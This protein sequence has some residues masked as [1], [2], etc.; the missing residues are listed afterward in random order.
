MS[1]SNLLCEGEERSPDVILLRVLLAG[2][3]AVEPSGSKFGMDTRVLAWRAA[4]PGSTAA[5]LRDADLAGQWPR[6]KDRPQ[7]WI[8]SVAGGQSVNLGWSWSRTEIENYLIDPAVVVAALGHRAPDSGQYREILDRAAD[9]LSSYTAARVALSTSRIAV[10]QLNNQWGT[11]RGHDKHAFPKS[12]EKSS[13]RK[14]L[15]RKVRAYAENVIPTEKQV[16]GR[17]KALLHEFGENGIRRSNY[18]H[19]YSGKDLL[20]QIDDELPSI[21]FNDF[22]AFREA[23]LLGIRKAR[24]ED[25]IQWVPEWAELRHQVLEFI[26]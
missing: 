2:I 3:C 6:D 22:G 19:T 18:L 1:V 13:C 10:K 26:L 14:H 16:V 21:G 20:I 12:L 5:C 23:I 15:R 11:P 7:E 9:R 24:Y 25:M 8:K 4:S 17:F